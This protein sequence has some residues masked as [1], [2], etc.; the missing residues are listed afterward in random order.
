MTE[1]RCWRCNKRLPVH[2]P[3]ARE[4]AVITCPRCRAQ[5][6]VRQ[7]VAPKPLDKAYQRM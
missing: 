5:N 2:T 7:D 1:M 6:V 4:D 3:P